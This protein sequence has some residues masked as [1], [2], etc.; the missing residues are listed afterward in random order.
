MPI[1]CSRSSLGSTSKLHL[2]PDDS[3]EWISTNVERS[4]T[5]N[6][7]AQAL[8][9]CTA[10]IRFGLVEAFGL[11]H[12]SEGSSLWKKCGPLCFCTLMSQ[13]PAKGSVC[14]TDGAK[15]YRWLSSPLN[16]GTLEDAAGLKLSHACVK[17]KPPHPEFSKKMRVQVWVARAVK[18]WRDPENRWVF[19]EFPTRCWKT[20]LQHC[21]P[22]L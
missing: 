7:L 18:S 12:H 14:R 17:H 10:R 21:R 20:P 3:S 15:A 8:G 6:C 22:F 2:S 1:C 19:R 4:S 13:F 16:D 11:P 9:S 5:R